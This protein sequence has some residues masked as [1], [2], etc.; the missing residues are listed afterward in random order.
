MQ[1]RKAAEPARDIS[2]TFRI[3][4]T[5]EHTA[6]WWFKDFHSDEKSL[7]DDERSGRSS[8]VHS[9]HLRALINTNPHTTDRKLAAELDIPLMTISGRLKEIQKS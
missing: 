4:T 9:D 8:N 3:G 7:E 1:G 6:Q 5:N 2:K